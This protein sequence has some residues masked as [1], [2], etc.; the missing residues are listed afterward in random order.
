[1]AARLESITP[2]GS[3]YATQQFAALAS[4]QGNASFACDYVGQI[5][6]PEGF[7]SYPIYL[8]RRE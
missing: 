8:V 6:F 7:G 3:V 2:P 5:P 1:M 4:F